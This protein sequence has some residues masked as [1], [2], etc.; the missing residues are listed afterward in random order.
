M[1]IVFLAHYN[2]K[3]IQ[4]ENVR[5]NKN[6]E[7][8]EMM[9]LYIIQGISKKI[10]VTVVEINIHHNINEIKKIATI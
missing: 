5:T 7:H 2:I 9:F 1:I 6:E 8:H 4:K 3:V 10:I